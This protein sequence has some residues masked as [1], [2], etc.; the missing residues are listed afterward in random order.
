[1]KT[2]TTALL[3]IFAVTGTLSAQG[4]PAAK[5]RADLDKAV[6][7]LGETQREYSE[8]R[9]ALYRDINKLDDEALKLSRELRELEREE[10]NRNAD[11]ARL[12]REVEARKTDF[13]Y[14]SGIL[15]Q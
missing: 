5:A 14:A 10:A 8:L 9:R 13:E 4:D 11:K 15:A 6:A 2:I 3:A 7:D 12:E 1:M